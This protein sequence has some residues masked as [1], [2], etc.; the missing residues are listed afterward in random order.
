MLGDF[1]L[2]RV[3]VYLFVI[4]V[5]FFKTSTCGRA[6]KAPLYYYFLLSNSVVCPQITFQANITNLFLVYSQINCVLDRTSN[7][8]S[9]SRKHS[10]SKVTS[11]WQHLLKYPELSSVRAYKNILFPADKSCVTAP[12]V[13]PAT[14]LAIPAFLQRW[15]VCPVTPSCSQPAS[16]IIAG[17]K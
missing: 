8:Y 9:F 7:V 2:G 15:A 5:I 14:E 1:C 4:F 3:L 17:Q 13:P 10:K 12:Q 16:P 6:S 11:K